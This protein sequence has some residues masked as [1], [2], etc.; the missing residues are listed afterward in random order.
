M[1][2]S[3]IDYDLSIFTDIDVDGHE[4]DVRER[5][6]VLRNMGGGKQ[7]KTPKKANELERTISRMKQL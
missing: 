3:S 2:A 1:P 6:K 4:F 7:K 5:R